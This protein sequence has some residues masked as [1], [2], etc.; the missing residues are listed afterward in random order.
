MKKKNKKL[1][2]LK[3]TMRIRTLKYSLISKLVKMHL[4]DWK[5][6]YFKITYQKQQ[7]ISELFVQGRKVLDPKVSH[8]IIRGINSID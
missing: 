1:F 4:R 3:I 7:K 6:N 5:W 2:K 8:Y